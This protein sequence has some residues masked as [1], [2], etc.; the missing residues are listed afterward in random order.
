MAPYLRHLGFRAEEVRR[1]AAECQ[2]IPEASLEQRVRFAIG[3]LRPPRPRRVQEAG[4]DT[5][6]G[7]GGPRAST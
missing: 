5:R 6:A 1:A 7:P 3:Y 4:D 2:T